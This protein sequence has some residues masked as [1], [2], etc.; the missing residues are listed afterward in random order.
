MKTQELPKYIYPSRNPLQKNPL[1]PYRVWIK[2][3]D[4]KFYK[5]FATREIANS[6]C[7]ASIEGGEQSWVEELK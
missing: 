5:D 1:N 3:G 6:V 2:D 7:L 4:E